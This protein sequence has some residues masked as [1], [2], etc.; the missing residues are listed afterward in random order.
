MT[1]IPCYLILVILVAPALSQLGVVPIAAHLFVFYWGLVSFITP[2]VAIAAYVA[3]GISGGRPM[4][5]AF[6]AV[7]LGLVKYVVPFLFVYNPSLLLIG[8]VEDIIV[9]VGT[10]AIGVFFLSVG[11]EGF[12]L[13]GLRI[14]ERAV[15]I[16][17]G[18]M[19]FVPVL[20][21][22]ELTV[23]GAAITSAALIWHIKS[24][25]ANWSSKVGSQSQKEKERKYTENVAEFRE[26][27]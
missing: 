25:R 27:S 23:A 15:F 21:H 19:L 1:S 26:G 10:A 14:F 3:C 8:S 11:V 9:A 16:V 5:T 4:E 12:F 20:K 2:P 6:I 22:W 17:G 13:R 24:V 7:R 18:F